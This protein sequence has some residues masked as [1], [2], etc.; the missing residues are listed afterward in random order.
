MALETPW[1]QVAIYSMSMGREGVIMYGCTSHP[2]NIQNVT[3]FNVGLWL[4]R[5]K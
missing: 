4:I 3:P 2:S 1:R 5:L